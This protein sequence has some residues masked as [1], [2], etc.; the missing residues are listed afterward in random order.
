[1]VVADVTL[2]VGDGPIGHERLAGAL[3]AAVRRGSLRSGTRLPPSR[4]LAGSIGC[5]RSV[6][7]EAYGLLV[8]E[9]VLTARTG[10]GTWVAGPLPDLPAPPVGPPPAAAPVDLTP[11]VPELASFPRSRWRRALATALATAGH[12]DLAASGA[13]GLPRLRAEIGPYLVRTR[14]AAVT[15]DVAVAVTR[16]SADTL[17]RLFRIVRRLGLTQVAMVDPVA[18]R[19]R[20]LATAEGL[21]VVPVGVDRHGPRIDVLL[22]SGARAVVVA[23]TARHPCDCGPG[24]RTALLRWARQVDGVVIEHDLDGSLVAGRRVP[25][26]QSLGPDRVILLGSLDVTVGP[27]LGLGWMLLP[28]TWL[29]TVAPVLPLMAGPPALDQLALVELITSGDLDRHV[30]RMRT[31]YRSRARAF[32]AVLD[33]HLP[34]WDV[35][36]PDGS[37]HVLATMP[38]GSGAADAEALVRAAGE[39]GLVLAPVLPG[40]GL[41]AF[42]LGFA[43][44]RE[45]ETAT[46]GATLAAAVRAAAVRA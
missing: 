11:G 3:R 36:V 17:D 23:S 27:G 29:R 10:S 31:R 24:C 6:V 35:Q 4:D 45:S 38:A 46:A 7:T 5:S 16:G 37:T 44:L 22:R 18:A 12:Q 25:V 13:L 42:A 15:A 2:D 39:R 30:R 9:G 41:P 8:A 28:E 40:A 21:T 1:V 14:G 33:G 34:G 26:L 43:N 20:V 32:A 19:T